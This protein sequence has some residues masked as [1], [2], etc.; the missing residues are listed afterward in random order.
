MSS[1][2]TPSAKA[3][4]FARLAASYDRIRPVDESWWEVFEL[5]VRTADLRGQR[6]LDVGCGTGR[7]AAALAERELARVWGVDPS[8]EMLAQARKNVPAGV[9]LKEGQAERLPFRDGWFERAVMWLSV[10]LVARQEALAELRRVL[11]AGGRL[12][13]VTFDPSHFAGFWL[14]AFFPSME[15]IDRERFPT[16]EELEH[17]LAAAGFAKV[18]LER[19]SQRR[20][21]T[22]AE[23]IERIRGRHISTFDLLDEDEVRSGT[24]RAEH[25]LPECFDYDVEWLIAVAE[26]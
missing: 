23:A 12:A 2:R 14:S 3:P 11:R 7:L 6:V 15:R 25:E 9:G 13:V 18:E 22:R 17:E 10:H 4:D 20:T 5:V 1:S 21:L 8:E 24:E 26:R 19:L 16:G